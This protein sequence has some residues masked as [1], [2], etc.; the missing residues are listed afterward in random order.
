MH[1][2][3]T[4]FVEKYEKQSVEVENL[5]GVEKKAWT[6]IKGRVP[7]RLF[8]FFEWQPQPPLVVARFP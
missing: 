5:E 6:G 1:A 4:E 3:R 8:L 7:R 2:I